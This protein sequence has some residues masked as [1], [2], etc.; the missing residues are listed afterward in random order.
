MNKRHI[1]VLSIVIITIASISIYI[2]LVMKPSLTN[3]NSNKANPFAIYLHSNLSITMD[4]RTIVIPSQIGINETL[5]KNHSL[6]KFGVPGMPMDEEG[7]TTMPGMAPL[8]TTNNNG[9][10]TVGSIVERNYTLHDFLN[11]WGGIDLNDKKVNAM[12]NGKPV[13]DYKNIILKDKE[14]IKLDIYSLQ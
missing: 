2:E 4:N 10:I 7:K 11:I 14:Q 3:M 5:W 8:Y 9:R 1:M 12:V 6:D 13:T